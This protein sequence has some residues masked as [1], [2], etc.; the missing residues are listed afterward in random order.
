MGQQETHTKICLQN[1]V[2]T[3]TWLATNI[4]TAVSFQWAAVLHRRPS[5]SPVQ[6]AATKGLRVGMRLTGQQTDTTILALE[7][8]IRWALSRPRDPRLHGRRIILRLEKCSTP[9]RCRHAHR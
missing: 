1:T 6:L 7:R 8:S 3:C 2:S 9:S 5:L 4:P